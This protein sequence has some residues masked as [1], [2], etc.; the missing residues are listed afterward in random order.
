[1]RREHSSLWAT[2]RLLR[3]RIQLGPARYSFAVPS[4]W[5]DTCHMWHDMT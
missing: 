5:L 1:M 2:Q 4:Q 3:C